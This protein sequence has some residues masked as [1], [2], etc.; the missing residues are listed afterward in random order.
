MSSNPINLALRFLLEI[1]VLIIL[2]IWGW[3]K[4]NGFVQY[5]LGFG[6]PLLTAFLW[7]TFRVPNDPGTAPVA[8]PGMLRLGFELALFAFATWALFDLQ[9]MF[10]AWA[11][12]IITILH[13]LTS[14]DRIFRI[15]KQ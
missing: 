13:Y 8:I 9:S 6:I 15:I 7:A 4:G 3:H 10:V 2:G 1:A 11:L 14:Y 12:G 5:L